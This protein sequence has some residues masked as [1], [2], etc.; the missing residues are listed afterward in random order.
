MPWAWCAACRLK[1]AGRAARPQYRTAAATALALAPGCGSATVFCLQPVPPCSCWPDAGHCALL[2]AASRAPVRN[3]PPAGSGHR[4]A[5]QPL[6]PPEGSALQRRPAATV[7]QSAQAEPAAGRHGVVRRGVPPTRCAERASHPGAH[8]AAR[9]GRTGSLATA[10]FRLA[11]DDW[12]SIVR[13]VLGH[14]T[15]SPLGGPRS[16]WCLSADQCAQCRVGR[17]STSPPPQPVWGGKF[18]GLRN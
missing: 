15:D 16:R 3:H 1:K 18:L 13:G 7:G 12:S 5:A 8:L 6:V 14:K 9:S 2:P 10:P 11:K 4:C 17:E